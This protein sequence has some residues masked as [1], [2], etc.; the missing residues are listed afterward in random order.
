MADFIPLEVEVDERSP[1]TFGKAAESPLTS[2]LSELRR[3]HAYAAGPQAGVVSGFGVLPYA[4]GVDVEDMARRMLNEAE[5]G[6]DWWAATAHTFT[7]VLPPGNS[8]AITP[9][10]GSHSPPGST[11]ERKRLSSFAFK[12]AHRPQS[13][14]AEGDRSNGDGKGASVES[15][16]ISSSPVLDVKRSRRFRTLHVGISGTI[17]HRAAAQKSYKF[18]SSHADNLLRSTPHLRHLSPASVDLDGRGNFPTSRSFLSQILSP[19]QQALA[20]GLTTQSMA[21]EVNG[22]SSKKGKNSFSPMVDYGTCKARSRANRQASLEFAAFVRVLAHEMSLEQFAAVETEVFTA[23]FALVHSNDSINR[24]AGVAALDA[25]IDVPSADEEK[26]Q[27]KFANNLSN[28]LRAN[29]VEYEFLAAIAGALGCMAVGAANLDYGEFEITRSLEWLRT[30][31]SDRRLAAVLT[32]KELARNAPTAFYTKTTQ[33]NGAHGGSND[34]IDYI[35]PVLLDP[36]PIVRACAAD[37]LGACL[38]VIIERQPKSTTGLLCQVFSSMMDGFKLSNIPSNGSD[39]GNI[40]EEAGQHA[41]L[42][43]LSEMLDHSPKFMLPRLEEVSSA[44]LE[45]LQH[46]KALI[47]LEAIRLIPRVAQLSPGSFSRRYL[48]QS[49]KF[50]VESATSPTSPKVGVDLRPASYFAMGQ[51][52]LAMKDPEREGI[53]RTT[54]QIRRKE[55]EHIGDN[56]VLETNEY[57]YNSLDGDIYTRLDEIFALVRTGLKVSDL[58]SRGSAGVSSDTRCEALHCGADLVE[59]LGEHARHYIGDLLQCMFATG[60]SKDLILCMRAIAS[61]LP[62][63]KVSSRPPLLLFVYLFSIHNTYFSPLLLISSTSNLAFFFYS[64]SLSRIDC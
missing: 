59:A 26:K 25:L 45:S 60:L 38:K 7:F 21:T 62:S 9:H 30:D 32:L 42:L 10:E 6:E 63:E 40:T 43:C 28:G 16:V 48:K 22:G 23:I 55:N 15:P 44:V 29:N 35:F 2:L 33:S 12:K 1:G 47:R 61:R 39:I 34:F 5:D 52:A 14:P 36:Q 4:S 46:P 53:I 58:P 54:I 41:S 11:R 64:S 3:K 50:L 57:I 31:R 24:L 49:L 37:A 17:G 20:P 19:S 18:A 56:A 8:A 13:P 27:I 51:V